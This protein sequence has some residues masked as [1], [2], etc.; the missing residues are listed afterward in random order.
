MI[1]APTFWG[2]GDKSDSKKKKKKK[3]RGGGLVWAEAYAST[4]N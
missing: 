3:K 1:S 2:E 4:T